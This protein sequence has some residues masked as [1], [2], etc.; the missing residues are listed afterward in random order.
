MNNFAPLKVIQEVVM[1]V[2]GGI[3]QYVAPFISHESDTM[4]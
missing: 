1:G 2:M 3:M 4:Q